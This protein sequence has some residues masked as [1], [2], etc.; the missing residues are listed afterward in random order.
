M[1]APSEPLWLDVYNT[2][3]SNGFNVA[4]NGLFLAI[5]CGSLAYCLAVSW[6]TRRCLPFSLVVCIGYI[7]EI[8]AYALK[9]QSWY[10]VSYTTNFGLSLIAPVFITMGYVHNY[11]A[12]KINQT[13]LR[14]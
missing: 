6:K 14:C 3:Y 7:L 12:R 2:P 5:I 4:A 13:R 8:T 9:F 11:S 1:V 10:I